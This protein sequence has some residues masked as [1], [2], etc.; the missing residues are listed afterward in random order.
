MSVTRGSVLKSCGK[1]TLGDDRGSS[2][3]IRRATTSDAAAAA[4]LLHDF[5][6]EYDDFTPGV[7]ALTERLEELLAERTIVVLQ[8]GDPPEGF[9]CSAHAH[10]SG[11]KPATP[12]WKSST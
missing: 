11:Q 10:R 3:P 12:I 1:L 5:N 7:P 8:A 9:A 6:T 4:R 2:Q